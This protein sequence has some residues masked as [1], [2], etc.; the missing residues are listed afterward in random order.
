MTLSDIPDPLREPVRAIA[1]VMAAHLKRT[2]AVP[3]RVLV[4]ADVAFALAEELRRPSGGA[5]A[6]G[7]RVGRIFGVE[8]V[9]K[10]GD[11]TDI[12]VVA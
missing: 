1:L 7:E 9:V 12:E 3:L 4:T 2:G 11:A 5:I 6:D 10:A 8:T